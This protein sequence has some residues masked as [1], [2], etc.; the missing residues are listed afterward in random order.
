MAEADV[1]H[2]ARRGQSRQPPAE[3]SRRD[4]RAQ[5]SR[6]RPDLH[7]HHLRVRPAH[8]RRRLEGEDRCLQCRVC[9]VSCTEREDQL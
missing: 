2:R 8:R 9:H 5:P 7:H 1:S 6:A 3:V 4:R